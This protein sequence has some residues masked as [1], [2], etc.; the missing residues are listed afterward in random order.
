[1]VKRDIIQYLKEGNI[2][3]NEKCN[4]TGSQKTYIHFNLSHLKDVEISFYQIESLAMSGEI[5]VIRH[6][7]SKLC[8]VSISIYM[9]EEGNA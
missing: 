9:K 8:P 2:I 5:D 3:V 6:F 4:K 1:M 7:K